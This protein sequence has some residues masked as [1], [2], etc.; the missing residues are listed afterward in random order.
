[1]V[2][3]LF[4]VQDATHHPRFSV[5]DPEYQ[6]LR[7]N[8]EIALLLNGERLDA[9]TEQVCSAYEDAHN[10]A[11][12]RRVTSIA[13]HL[14]GTQ[15][16]VARRIGIDRSSISVAKDHGELGGRSL[17]ALLADPRVLSHLQNTAASFFNE[18]G[19][20]AFIA[21]AQVTLKFWAGSALHEAELTDA[22]YESLCRMIAQETAGGPP[23]GVATQTL[24]DGHWIM[25]FAYVFA[26]VEGL[27]CEGLWET[28]EPS[29]I[30]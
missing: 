2:H 3:S 19:R 13:L 27:G 20:A 6:R 28:P 11:F 17:A 22:Y 29:E 5:D 12:I 25:L 4:L 1:M 16:A 21:A 10:A 30:R 14:D 23:T 26:T 8:F 9:F 18:L 15:Q 7:D 24:Q